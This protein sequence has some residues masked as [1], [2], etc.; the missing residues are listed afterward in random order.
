[1]PDHSQLTFASA[2]ALSAVAA[3]VYLLGV[4]FPREPRWLVPLSALVA[5]PIAYFMVRSSTRWPIP[6]PE[7]WTAIATVL[8]AITAVIGVAF[9]IRTLRSLRDQDVQNAR[10]TA[11]LIEQAWPHLEVVTGSVPVLRKNRGY[12]WG[13]I[14]H[15]FG[16]TPA[17]DVEIWL[18]ERDAY[19]FVTLN[20]VLPSRILSFALN[21][22]TGQLITQNPFPV[23][24]D[25]PL[26]RQGWIGVIWRCPDGDF[27]YELMAFTVNNRDEL[28]W[29]SPNRRDPGFRRQLSR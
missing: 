22:A 2:Y 6:D 26:R 10:Q 14:R 29:S 16:T 19:Y 12:W 27:R 20:L 13:E 17:R 21:E 4:W 5:A 7:N 18:R 8:I 24:D 23:L 28:A 9:G 11:A 15:S 25:P 3:W 1:M